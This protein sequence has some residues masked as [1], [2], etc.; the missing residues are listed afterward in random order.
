MQANRQLLLLVKH[1]RKKKRLESLR[2]RFGKKRQGGSSPQFDSDSEVF[3]DDFEQELENLIDEVDG[4]TEVQA[5]APQTP[6]QKRPYWNSQPYTNRSDQSP[7]RLP[8]G[9]VK[10]VARQ[11]AAS[12]TGLWDVWHCSMAYLFQDLCENGFLRNRSQT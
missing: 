2:P 6:P 3:S 9:D 5:S 7:H 12:R 4:S 8:R 1:G 10:K 11:N